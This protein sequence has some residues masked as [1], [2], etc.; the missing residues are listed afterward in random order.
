MKNWIIIA[1]SWYNLRDQDNIQNPQID[2]FILKQVAKS[3]RVLYIPTASHDNLDYYANFRRVYADILGC[4]VTPLYLYSCKYSKKELKDILNQH[5]LVYVGWGNTIQMLKKWRTVGFER[6]L[7]DYYQDWGVVAGMSAW[8]SCW[9]SYGI[10][11]DMKY[12]SAIG[13]IGHCFR[14]HYIQE[15]ENEIQRKLSKKYVG[16]TFAFSD[17]TAY[18]RKNGED[19]VWVFKDQLQQ[20][21]FYRNKHKLIAEK[22][23][24]DKGVYTIKSSLAWVTF[25]KAS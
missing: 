13:L 3:K 20:E 11:D 5:D 10:T 8:A 7:R 17:H 16:T 24:L 25:Q 23:I 21:V 12:C 1:V 15:Q 2:I 9:F 14:P 18:I 6:V 22:F 4:T 19:M